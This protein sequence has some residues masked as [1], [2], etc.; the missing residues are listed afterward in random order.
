[1]QMMGNSRARAVYEAN[2]PEDH[3]RPQTDN[4]LESFIRDKYEKKK[5]LAR[6]WVPSKPPDLPQGWDGLI[7]AE[8]LA[9]HKDFK[10]LA[11]PA[12]TSRGTSPR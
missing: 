11:L 12:A 5:Y 7:E 2:V 9:K 4:A 10:K 1:M 6:E 8:K 3:R